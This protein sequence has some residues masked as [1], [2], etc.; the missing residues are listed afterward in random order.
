MRFAKLAVL[1]LVA[2]LG[3]T[4]LISVAAAHAGHDH[5]DLE[6]LATRVVDGERIELTTHTDPKVPAPTQEA[7][8]PF[9]LGD[10]PLPT[11]WCGDYTSQDDTVHAMHA[12]GK[13]DVKVIYAIARDQFPANREARFREVANRLQADVS[14]VSQ[15]VAEASGGR[16]TIRFDRGNRCGSGY[17]D[18]QSV[19]IDADLATLVPGGV[20]DFRLITGAIEAQIGRPTG[21]RNHFVYLDGFQTNVS[22]GGQGDWW[23]SD[24]SD[25]PIHDLGDLYA[26]TYGPATLPSSSYAN[27]TT[28]LHE[29]GHNLGAVGAGSPNSTLVGHCTDEWDVMCYGENGRAAVADE[30]NCA[31]VWSRPIVQH[32]DCHGD[33]YFNA[34]PAAGSYLDERWNVFHSAHLGACSSELRDT[35][36]LSTTAP[37]GTP[38]TNTTAPLP[39]T[40]KTNRQVTLGA[41]DDESGVAEYQWRIDGGAVQTTSTATLTG[42]GFRTLSTRMRD[43]AGNWSA[44]RHDEVAL[45]G[46]APGVVTACPEGWQRWP[47]SCTVTASDAGTGVA[48]I[49]YQI[50]DEGIQQVSDQRAYV[51]M[52]YEGTSTLRVRAVDRVGNASPWVT[53]TAQLDLTDPSAAISCPDGWQ[54]GATTCVVSGSDGQSGLETLTWQVDGEGGDPRAVPADGRI[55]ISADGTRSVNVVAT[56]RAGRWKLARDSVQ[57]DSSPPTATVSCSS[58]WR[59]TAASCSA[60]VVDLSS[61]VSA[62]YYRVDGGSPIDFTGSTLTTS[63]EG[64]HTVQVMAVNAAGVESAWSAPATIRTDFTAP[65]ATVGCPPG[66]QGYVPATCQLTSF[67]SGSGVARMERQVNGTIQS[68]GTSGTASVTTEGESTVAARTYD[69][70]GNVSPWTETTVKV[71]SIVPRVAISCPE[72]WSATSVRCRVTASDAGSGLDR[73]FWHVDYGESHPV[74]PGEMITVEGTTPQLVSVMAFD[75]AGRIGSDT[76]RARLDATPPTVT[77]ACPEGWQAEAAECSMTATDDESGVSEREAL[78]SGDE[79]FVGETGRFVVSRTGRHEVE[80]RAVNE[81]GVWSVAATSAVSVDITDPTATIACDALGAGRHSCLVQAGDTGS[82]VDAVRLVRD[83]VVG[84]PVAPGVAFELDGPLNVAARVTD[85]VGR[86]TTSGEQWLWGRTVTEERDDDDA[87]VVDPSGGGDDT[88]TPVGPFGPGGPAGPMGPG[89]GIDVNGHDDDEEEDAPALLATL[90][91]GGRSVGT[92]SVTLDGEDGEGSAVVVLDPKRLPAGTWR[93]EVCVGD[94]CVRRTVRLRR[95]GRPPRIERVL[96]VGSGPLRARFRISRKTRRGFRPYA[97]GEARPAER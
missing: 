50:D 45:D 92:G 60:N 59:K 43:V 66:W 86:A 63:V 1:C 56:D 74:T 75:K 51:S 78:V 72:T 73:V 62:R 19:V 33:D 57:I 94:R 85:R 32:W 18:I 2:L 82:G 52:P 13:P 30:T 3:P 81:A 35:C 39:A 10:S 64:E 80:V 47:I 88:S 20:P 36:G 91:R 24:A 68:I 83:G 28:M 25:T 23:R 8:G 71:D 84:D 38:P 79:R 12:P 34:R 67:D 26:V 55:T 7:E 95:G 40:S 77:V 37:D 17:A 29:I 11:T 69:R 53:D 6:V 58:D 41:Y 48:R 44:W 46:T 21:P 42:E 27:P 93:L 54:G 49:E 97:A 70:A 61:G 4:G 89:P 76:G 65:A 87:L 22:A 31:R 14:Y 9:A 15:F 5:D 16:R 96:R 90:R